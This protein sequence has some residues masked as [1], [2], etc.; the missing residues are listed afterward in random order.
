MPEREPA[1]GLAHICVDMQSMFAERTD[2]HAPWLRRVL[3]AV[4]ALVERAPA[5]TVFTRFIPPPTPAQAHGAWRFHYER[6]PA[7]TRERLPPDLLDIVPSLAR[8][9]PPARVFDKP[10][11]SPWLDGRLDAK[12]RA[13]GVSTLAVSGG[14]TD[15]CVLATV[16]GGIDLGYRIVLATDAVFGSA[17]ATHDDMLEIYRCRFGV[18][19]TTC[20][21]QELLDG[22]ERLPA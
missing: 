5:Q 18:Q 8:F 19:L 12:L 10:V 14:E 4:E 11:Y 6:W 21:T 13:E 15:M 17:D 2:W 3:P 9:V 7:M 22:W 16:L 1:G 20:T